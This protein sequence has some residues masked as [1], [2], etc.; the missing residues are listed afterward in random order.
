VEA[1]R[2]RSAGR[3]RPCSH[4]R[5]AVAPYTGDDDLTSGLAGFKIPEI[6]GKLDQGVSSIDDGCIPLGVPPVRLDN[7][8]LRVRGG[9]ALLGGL[10][11]AGSVLTLGLIQPWREIFPAFTPGVGG[12]PASVWLAAARRRG[13]PL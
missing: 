4:L 6:F 1:G 7:D 9:E 10:F 12:E 11:L 5:V 2:A 13:T 3:R 8:D